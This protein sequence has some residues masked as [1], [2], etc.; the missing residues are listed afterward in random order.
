[1]SSRAALFD[2][3]G[4]LA[5][6]NPLHVVAWWEAFRQ[7][8]H[9]VPTA[10]IH[11]A[12]GLGGTDLI[13]RLLGPGRDTEVD[14]TIKTAHQALYGTY[15]ERLPILPGARELLHEVARRDW[16]VIVVTS[17]EDAELTAL[18]KALDADDVITDVASAHQV[19]HGKPA[20][21]QVERALD[22]AGTPAHR[23]VFVGDSV[24]DMRAATRAGVAALGLLSGGL[25]EADLRENG[26]R[27]VYRDPAELLESLG[28]STFADLAAR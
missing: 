22:L 10:A 15:F 8:G 1:M 23:A 2:L 21:D 6:T 19:R 12:L 24:W 25:P 14:E 16:R 17:A 28:T 11:H 20:P 5:D 18:R 3:D 26:A 27:E 4:T 9:P 7:A 13:A